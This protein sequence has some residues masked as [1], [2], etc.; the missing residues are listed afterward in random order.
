MRDMP[1]LLLVVLAGFAWGAV[2]LEVPRVGGAEGNWRVNRARL[3]H[4]HTAEV[5]KRR[6]R[7]LPFAASSAWVQRLGLR[8]KEEWED[9]LDLG[10]GWSVYV[11]SDPETYYRAR[12]EWLGWCAWLTGEGL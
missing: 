12:G 6:A 9:W 10:E 11:P 7:F 5:G 8:T 2:A 3:M 4:R 1:S